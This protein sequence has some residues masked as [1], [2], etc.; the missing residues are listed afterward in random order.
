MVIQHTSSFNVLWEEPHLLTPP[1]QNDIQFGFSISHLYTGTQRHLLVGA[2]KATNISSSGSEGSARPGALYSCILEQ[3][4]TGT[5]TPT[6]TNCK[7]LK[8]NLDDKYKTWIDQDLKDGQRLGYSLASNGRDTLVVCAPRWHIFIDTS[9]KTEDF[10]LGICYYTSDLEA[11]LTPFSPPHQVEEKR[12]S[13]LNN[14]AC[15]FGMSVAYIEDHDTYAFGSPGCWAWQG[16]TWEIG[17][18]DVEDPERQRRVEQLALKDVDL[19]Q[20]SGSSGFT[21]ITDLY[22]GFSVASITYSGRSAIVSSMPRTTSTQE[23][24]VINSERGKTVGP[25]IY[26]LEQDGTNA[27]KLK[28]LDKILPPGDQR[29]GEVNKFMFFG[30]SL[31]TLD[32]N[33]DGLEDLVVSAP[34]YNSNKTQYDQGAIFVYTQTLITGDKTQMTG[35]VGA[36]LRKGPQPYGRFG[37]CVAAIGDIDGDDFQDL[38]V[39]APFL[40]GGGEVFIYMGSSGGLE[41]TPKQI[42]KASE[43]SL[44]LPR[45]VSIS[46]FGSSIAKALPAASGAGYDVA[47]G[48]HTSDTVLVFRTK[49]VV[50]FTWT[51]TFSGPIDLTSLSCP[52]RHDV[53]MHPCVTATVCFSYHTRNK[54]QADHEATNLEFSLS[55][56]AD[57]RQS[58][59]R[60]Y[61]EE[62]GDETQTVTMTVPQAGER[63]CSS[64]DVMAKLILEPSE[65]LMKEEPLTILVECEGGQVE[66]CR[67]DLIL[68]YQIIR[69]FTLG[70]VEP[71]VLSF[72]IENRGEAA[73]NTQLQ[74]K[75]QG[76]LRMDGMTGVTCDTDKSN[77]ITCH[78]DTI[79]S[80]NDKRNLT[81]SFQP[82]LTFFNSL[83]SHADLFTLRATVLTTSALTNPDTAKQNIQCPI[84]VKGSL[85]LS[86][87]PSEPPRVAYNASSYYK[88][89]SNNTLEE[90]VGPVVIHRYKIY[91]GN[92]FSIYTTRVFIDWPYRI[93]GKPLLYLLDYP[94]FSGMVPDCEYDVGTV[95]VFDI[96]KSEAS[97]EAAR[98]IYHNQPDFTTDAVLAAGRGGG[99]WD[100]GMEFMRFTCTL[101][102][103]REGQEVSVVLQSRLV[104]ATIQ[105]LD[106]VLPNATSSVY[107]QVVKMPLGAPPPKSSY[108]TS[109][110]TDI[111]NQETEAMETNKKKDGEAEEEGVST[112]EG[113]EALVTPI[114]PLMRETE[115]D[116]E[117]QFMRQPSNI[118]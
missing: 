53:S 55:L 29:N 24:K 75:T 42:L 32:F 21:T 101:G 79:F 46:T 49:E 66:D 58:H 72:T 26:I 82:D 54:K 116:D 108:V 41:V 11:E 62:T 48:A 83:T 74:I 87:K 110:S 18:S 99:K 73:Y 97:T 3:D 10:P 102:E 70:D 39:G 35:E 104:M 65:A 31:A 98:G 91:N 81:L 43:L 61:F 7:Q 114:S 27:K 92:K 68:N 113:E 17:L 67:S 12:K 37:T 15:Q 88:L 71:L 57:I 90:E 112:G 118:P 5:G 63:T 52:S 2:P 30:Y 9:S 14:G 69:E 89:P 115:P 45:P 19:T 1:G 60:L 8:V 51:L 6:P 86:G 77:T 44:Q 117:F 40:E 22:L 23:L 93:D 38:A 28:I 105:Q 56:T 109:V 34:F 64:Q 25:I 59:K 13:Y 20:N 16:D 78:I 47:V 84:R 100:A 96:H 80:T 76:D 106:R 33:G 103:V 111:T 107:L 50:M 95:D 36:P 4:D 94:M 85:D